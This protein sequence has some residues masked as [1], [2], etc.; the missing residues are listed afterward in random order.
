[1]PYPDGVIQPAGN[2]RGPNTFVGQNLSRYTTD[3]DVRNPQAMRWAVN[4][5]RELPGQWVVEAGYTGNRGYDL[6]VETDINPVPREFLSNSE[7]RD[8]AHITRM[9]QLVPNPFAGL[10]PGTGLNATN[11]A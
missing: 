7:V 10:L 1:N 11:V 3:V 8:N 5:Q 4:V 2:S 9:S 6:T